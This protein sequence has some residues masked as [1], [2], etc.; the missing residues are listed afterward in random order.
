MQALNNLAELMPKPGSTT[1]PIVAGSDPMTSHNSAA[2]WHCVET[3]Y[4]P[5]VP[6]VRFRSEACKRGR[7]EAQD[8]WKT[9]LY[10]KC[11]HSLAT[12]ISCGLRA[13][14]RYDPYSFLESLHGH[15]GVIAPAREESN[16]QTRT[17][18][19]KIL[20]EMNCVLRDA[21]LRTA[22]QHEGGL[23]PAMPKRS[24]C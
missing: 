7:Y 3:R 19:R 15:L 10:S 12:V 4:L 9:M 20:A 11:R 22:P 18:K 21:V 8:G 14:S 5:P 24:S 1:W 16:S 2:L 17:R 13:K 6:R 23:G